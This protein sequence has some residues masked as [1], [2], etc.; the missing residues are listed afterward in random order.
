MKIWLCSSLPGGNFQSS[1][2]NNLLKA[3]NFFFF[4]WCSCPS[5]PKISTPANPVAVAPFCPVSGLPFASALVTPSPL[6]AVEGLSSS[7][8]GILYSVAGTGNGHALLLVIRFCNLGV[9]ES[10]VRTAARSDLERSRGVSRRAADSISDFRTLEPD[11]GFLRR[12]IDMMLPRC[13]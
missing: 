1:N 12:R 2:L 6:S 13:V 9:G 3:P 10:S 8:S 4:L 11:S 7:P 5:P